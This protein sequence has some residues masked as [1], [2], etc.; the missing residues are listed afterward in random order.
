MAPRGRHPHCRLT[1]RM[2][3]EAKPGRHA[4]GNGLHLFVRPTGARS[5]VQRLVIAGQRRDLGLG[6]CSLVPLT[7]ARRLALENRRAA[8]TGED[9]TAAHAQETAP[10][11]RTV[12]AAVIAARRTNWRNADTEKKWLRL[13]ETLVFPHIGDKPISQV[14]LT[15]VRDIIVPHWKGRGSIGYVLRQHLEH[16]FKWADAHGHMKDNPAQQLK[17]LL[18]K[19]KV[20]VEHHPSL[21][22]QKV[23]AAMAAVQASSTDDAVKLLLAFLVLCASRFTEAAEAPWSEIDVDRRLWTLPAGRTKGLREHRVPLSSQ[24]LGVLDR[25]RAL[26]RPGPLVFTTLSCRSAQPIVAPSAVARLLDMLELVDEKGRGV[27]VHGFRATFR[28]W[29][30]E[31]AQASREVCEAALAHVET[32]QTVA[33]Y[34]RGDLLDPRRLVMQ[35]WADYVLPPSGA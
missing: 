5:W 12:V 22:Y 25:M 20:V 19:V 11:V 28:E 10:T 3:R 24:A 2:V 7:E 13:F 4:D 29:A 6:S 16:V 34:A 30:R 31:Q 23:A 14:T 17:V 1:D 8:R 9:P 18:P 21:P 15:D 26:N 32:D 27:V 33:A 35:R